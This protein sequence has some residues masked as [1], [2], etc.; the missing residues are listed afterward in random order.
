MDPCRPS[1]AQK[2]ALA[3]DLASVFG[4]IV[5]ILTIAPGHLHAQAGDSAAVQLA[6]SVAVQLADSAA[7]QLA[8][9]AAAQV[10]DSPAAQVADT[11]ST[12]ADRLEERIDSLTGQIV[13][14]EA[15]L[16]ALTTSLITAQAQQPGAAAEEGDR[17]VL[18]TASDAL[19]DAT[20]V[21]N[22]GLR[23]VLAF[24][25][26]AFVF[27]LVKA[28]NWLLE[29]LAE[30]NASRRLL[31]KKLLPVARLVLWGLT[32]Y[33]V[34]AVIFDVDRAGL[35][36]ALAAI[37]IAVGFAAQDV[38]K[39]IFG[40]ILIV[41]DQPFQV[42]DKISVG[43]TYGE[44]VAIG[45]RSTRIVTPDDNLVSVPN[46]Q[47]V[48]SQVANANAGALDCQVVVDLF[49]PGWT[50]VKRAKEIAYEAAASS[51]FVFLDKPIRVSV[52][53]EVRE[54]FLTRIRVRAY[55]IDTRHE[56]ALASDI[57]EAAKSE[58]LRQGLLQPMYHR[59]MNT[60]SEA[61]GTLTGQGA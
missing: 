56:L 12:A 8:D 30:R 45:I 13:A 39:N 29:V 25:V 57:T 23:V 10:A 11:A 34:A 42:G 2:R 35:L 19:G 26:M 3:A 21:R 7:A 15:R 16:Q 31:L 37:G 17:T 1:I 59:G 49:L 38:L 20:Q 4:L 18:E 6:D 22:L 43:G 41:L 50:D 48:E 46:A 44:V 24:L 27:V 40:G 28:L 54:M 9:S 32:L 5:L 58:F 60:P 53:D 36:A 61:G 33:Y 51:R 47:V 14:L 52:A 55:V